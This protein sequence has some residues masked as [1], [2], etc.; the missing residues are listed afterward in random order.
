M[1]VARTVP[2][3]EL[4][5]EWSYLEL[6]STNVGYRGGNGNNWNEIVIVVVGHRVGANEH[7]L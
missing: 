1:W 4:S 5:P 3:T 2:E 7:G 6:E